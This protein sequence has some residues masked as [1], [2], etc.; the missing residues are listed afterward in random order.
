MLRP[1]PTWWRKSTTALDCSGEVEVL[2]V[3]LAAEGLLA[4]WQFG[5]YDT[6]YDVNDGGAGNG[7]IDIADVQVIASY[8]GQT[9]P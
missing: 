4:A 7:V 1:T 8:F 6:V 2:D 3:T 5:A 9:V